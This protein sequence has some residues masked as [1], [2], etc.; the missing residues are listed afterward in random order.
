[1]QEKSFAAKK[2]Y[3]DALVDISITMLGTVGPCRSGGR[4]VCY[5]YGLWDLWRR[6][7]VVAKA[8]PTIF[9]VYELTRLSCDVL[10]RADA[11]GTVKNRFVGLPKL[12]Y[13]GRIDS[14]LNRALKLLELLRVNSSAANQFYEQ[15]VEWANRLR[16]ACAEFFGTAE[17]KRLLR[18]SYDDGPQ[19]AEG[20][21][22]HAEALCKSP[23]WIARRFFLD[24]LT[25]F[26]TDLGDRAA[27]A[28]GVAMLMVAFR[29]SVHALG[30]RIGD[31]YLRLRFRQLQEDAE[32]SEITLRDGPMEVTEYHRLRHDGDKRANE[33]DYVEWF[34]YTYLHPWHDEIRRSLSSR[35]LAAGP[36]LADP[37]IRELHSIYMTDKGDIMIGLQGRARKLFDGEDARKTA[38]IIRQCCA[39][40]ICILDDEFWKRY[41][42]RHKNGKASSERS[43][44]SHRARELRACA[45][46]VFPDVSADWGRIFKVQGNSIYIEAK[47]A[48]FYQWEKCA[49]C[50]HHFIDSPETRP[51][52]P[53]CKTPRSQEVHPTLRKYLKERNDSRRRSRPP[54]AAKE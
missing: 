6:I 9:D 52:C 32:G 15:V 35:P 46:E 8:E 7:F 19:S 13:L 31:R 26:V 39:D 34:E 47:Q 28:A 2:K 14:G 36:R 53:K 51:V 3:G 22:S 23:P 30:E 40:G 27:A 10:S 38:D 45:E 33:M 17:H 50:S 16:N 18:L 37:P 41:N 11:C 42:D 1:M 48:P 12:E 4:D 43:A 5:V 21:G 44:V 49:Q 54:R 20:T 25:H 29:E 24:A